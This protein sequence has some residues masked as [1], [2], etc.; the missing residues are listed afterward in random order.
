VIPAGAKVYGRYG[1]MDVGNDRL[2][3]MWDKIVRSDGIIITLDAKG[4]DSSGKFGIPGD[5]DRRYGAMFQNSILVSGISLATAI[6][7]QKA[8][9]IT[10]QTQITNTTTGATTTTNMTP[11]NV[12][13]NSVVQTASDI[14]KQL[15][16]TLS[17]EVK[18][19][20]TI[21]QGTIVQVVAMQDINNIPPFRF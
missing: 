5:I 21:P 3:V 4:A 8:F 10:G 16:D 9:N 1:T 18:P 6:V 20:I 7:A 15:T 19:V 11:A 12:A 2:T 17:K 13:I 14:A